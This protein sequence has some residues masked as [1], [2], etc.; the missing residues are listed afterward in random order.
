MKVVTNESGS[1]GMF[2]DGFEDSVVF[3]SDIDRDFDRKRID[4]S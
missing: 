3:G 2:D 1:L 4:Q